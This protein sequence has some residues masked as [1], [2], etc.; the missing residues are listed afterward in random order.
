M[1]N[2]VTERKRLQDESERNRAEVIGA[3]LHLEGNE[4]GG[5]T[6]ECVFNGEPIPTF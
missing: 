2:D 4:Q 3:E 1:Q 5:A 6:L